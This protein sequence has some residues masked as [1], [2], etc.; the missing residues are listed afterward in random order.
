MLRVRE[1]G[2]P[3]KRGAARRGR[4]CSIGL[5]SPLRHWRACRKT[6]CR[7][8]SAIKFADMLEFTTRF[9]GI[10]TGA[11]PGHARLSAKRATQQAIANLRYM[12]RPSAVLPGNTVIMNLPVLPSA[13]CAWR[14][15]KTICCRTLPGQ[16][17]RGWQ[18]S[19][20]RG[21]ASQRV[22]ISQVTTKSRLWLRRS[23][24]KRSQWAVNW[25]HGNQRSQHILERRRWDQLA[26]SVFRKHLR[27]QAGS[28][29]CVG[30]V[31]T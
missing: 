9:D 1:F 28:N 10:T 16:K 7:V 23:R 26:V 27:S 18:A 24:H 13:R 2:Q 22:R 15:T 25:D 30:G 5:S 20:A 19:A 29:G 4:I 17:V 21:R 31:N 12:A 6:A 14:I 11:R 3:L 8:A